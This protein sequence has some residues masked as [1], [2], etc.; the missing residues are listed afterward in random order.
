[1]FQTDQGV[2]EKDNDNEENDKD[3]DLEESG[4]ISFGSISPKY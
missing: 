4:K 1:M 3:D 2:E